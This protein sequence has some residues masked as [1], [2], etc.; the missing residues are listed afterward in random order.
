MRISG[1]SCGPWLLKQDE[2]APDVYHAIGNAAATYGT[3][4]KLV[5]LE[6]NLRRDDEDSEAPSLWNLQAT[7]SENPDLSSKGAGERIYRGPL[8]WFQAVRF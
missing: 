1:L 8:E 2:M 3:K 7:A 6:V 5:R 4:L